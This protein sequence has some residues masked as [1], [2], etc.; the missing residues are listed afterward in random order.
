MTERA[1]RKINIRIYISANKKISLIE[2]YCLGMEEGAIEYIANASQYILYKLL[3]VS[4]EK[5]KVNSDFI[6]VKPHLKS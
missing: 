6:G 3:F 4:E 1:T 5:H 2:P